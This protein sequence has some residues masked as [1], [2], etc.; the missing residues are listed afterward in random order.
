VPSP[1]E[2]QLEKV[3]HTVRK[4]P[5]IAAYVTNMLRQLNVPP[6]WAHI[7]SDGELR[8]KALFALPRQEYANDLIVPMAQPDFL[9]NYAARTALDE[10]LTHALPR[11]LSGVTVHLVQGDYDAVVSNEQTRNWL[12]S[13][14]VTLTCHTV[15]GAG[16]YI[17]DL[18][19]P[20]LRF[21]LD[22][23]LVPQTS[24]WRPAR[25]R[26]EAAAARLS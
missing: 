1:F 10:D 16:H 25:I 13:L 8:A 3:F 20:Y 22:Q 26:T 23:I 4:S 9:I 5:S 2:D 24:A 21:L 12:K 7:A 11:F 17:Q 18:Q 14:D 19:Y 15:S 6:K